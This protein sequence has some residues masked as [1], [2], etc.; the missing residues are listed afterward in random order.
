VLAVLNG[1]VDAGAT[2]ANSP[3]A[4]TAWMR[5]LKILRMS[6][7]SRHCVF[8][9]D[10]AEMVV[11]ASLN[12][13]IA[14]KV[15]DVFVEL[16]RDPKGKA[17]AA[18]ALSNRRLRSRQRPKTTTRCARLSSTPHTY[19][20]HPTE[21]TLVILLEINDLHQSYTAA[22]GAARRQSQA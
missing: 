7:S 5:Y 21:K 15:E 20:R 8:R 4:G 9:A 1:K 17:N 2:Y 22:C 10:P 13:S 3:T 18:R 6:S 14:K 16:S 12:P 19:Q 11:S